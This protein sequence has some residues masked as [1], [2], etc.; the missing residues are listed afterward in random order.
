MSQSQGQSLPPIYITLEEY[1]RIRQSAERATRYSWESALS[2][3]GFSSRE[4]LERVRV[5]NPVG[6]DFTFDAEWLDSCEARFEANAERTR[7]RQEAR[8]QRLELEAKMKEI[9]KAELAKASLKTENAA[10][11]ELDL[12]EVKTPTFPDFDVRQTVR[13]Q[14][15]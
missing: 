12:P 8:Q 1:T 10:R 11:R 6:E 2:S 4:G 5:R 13:V 3:T 14:A 7:R 15:G 9:R